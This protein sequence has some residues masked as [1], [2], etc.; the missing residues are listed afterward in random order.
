MPFCLSLRPQAQ[1]SLNLQ[2][3]GVSSL[4]TAC[5]LKHE[6]HHGDTCLWQDSTW[7][8]DQ[9]TCGNTADVCARGHIVN[10]VAQSEITLFVQVRQIFWGALLFQPIMT[11]LHCCVCPRVWLPNQDF[12]DKGSK[13]VRQ[14]RHKGVWCKIVAQIC[15][16]VAGASCWALY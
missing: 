9:L 8:K 10:T 11:L 16:V 4:A 1:K 3:K 5:L 2:K 15:P 12:C 7:G 13:F 14:G 6:G